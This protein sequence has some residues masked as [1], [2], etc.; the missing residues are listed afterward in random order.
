MD[1]LWQGAMDFLG[2]E[3]DPETGPL[4]EWGKGTPGDLS[5]G[6]GNRWIAR[7]TDSEDVLDLVVDT[8]KKLAKDGGEVVGEG[9]RGAFGAPPLVVVIA[10]AAAFLAF[11]K[12]TT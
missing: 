9:V 5:P 10:L 8:G 4:D 6:L 1:E 11:R 2:I 7:N 3:D 12:A